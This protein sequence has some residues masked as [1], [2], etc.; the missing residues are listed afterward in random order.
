MNLGDFRKLTANL[1]DDSDI[2]VD[3][4]DLEFMEVWLERRHILP[5]VLDHSYAVWLSAGQVVNYELDMDARVDAS[6]YF[7]WEPLGLCGKKT[8]H[9]PHPH[10]SP[11]LGEFY[12]HADQ[13]KRLPYA[14][15]MRR[16]ETQHG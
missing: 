3:L 15:E 5:P 10:E 16:G 2:L 11:T 8:V 12:C 14:A 9:E 13:S 4:G 1:P 6:H 7:S